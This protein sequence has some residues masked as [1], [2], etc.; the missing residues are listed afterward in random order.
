MP[1]REHL[2]RVFWERQAA[3]LGYCI[4]RFQEASYRESL[5]R[6]SQDLLAFAAGSRIERYQDVLFQANWA[7][8]SARCYWRAEPLRVRVV[9]RLSCFL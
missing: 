4:G 5:V 9:H 3:E 7:W 6:A 2:V 8:V 1:I